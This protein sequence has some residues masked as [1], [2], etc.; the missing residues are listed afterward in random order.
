[1]VVNRVS[2]INTLRKKKPDI[3]DV[4]NQS[5]MPTVTEMQNQRLDYIVLVARMLVEYF[6]AL[7]PFKDIV[8]RHIP[9]KHSKQM[10]EKST[11]VNNFV[12]LYLGVVIIYG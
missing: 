10:S 1:V 2:G 6:T 7:S 8:I 5:F 9:H 12:V 4:P 3:L 11:K